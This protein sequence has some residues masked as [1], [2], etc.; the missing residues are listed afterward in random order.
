LR[1]LLREPLLHFLAIGAV[2]FAAYALVTRHAKPAGTIV[3]SRGQ[4]ET[5]TATFERTWQR[6]PTPQELDGLVRDY[7]I[8]EACA[9]EA[10]ALGLDQDDSVIRRRLQQ[11]LEFL[12]VTGAAGDP[13]DAQL[14]EFL[15]SHPALFRKEDHFSFRHVYFSPDRR[16]PQLQ[17]DVQQALARLAASGSNAAGTGLG[18]PFLLDQAFDAVPEGEIA[19]R[20]GDKFAKALAGLPVRSWQGPVESSYGVHLV[21]I[22]ERREGGL[23]ALAEAREQVRREW[24]E[25]A[26]VDAQAKF[27]DEILKRYRVIIEPAPGAPPAGGPLAGAPR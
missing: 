21:F 16:G 12:D 23:P 20:F 6:P 3:V 22:S 18:D 13:T 1:R 10:I 15:Q 5:L 4:I 14:A 17:T 9:R 11:K 27:H 26:R 24:R 25:A 19:M 7:V 2:L 8:E